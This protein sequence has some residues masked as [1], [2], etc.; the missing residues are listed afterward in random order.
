MLQMVRTWAQNDNKRSYRF[1][2]EPWGYPL[3]C[4]AIHI[5]VNN[6]M[7]LAYFGRPSWVLEWLVDNMC[8]IEG[9]VCTRCKAELILDVK[10]D[11]ENRVV[12]DPTKF[13]KGPEDFMTESGATYTVTFVKGVMGA[14]GCEYTDSNW[15]KAC[16]LFRRALTP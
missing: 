10:Y 14:G 16:K 3:R 1:E 11:F 2:W 4:E 7:G 5:Q 12:P 15:S 13:P 8:A 6:L 9:N